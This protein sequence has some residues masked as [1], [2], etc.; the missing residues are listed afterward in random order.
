MMNSKRILYGEVLMRKQSRFLKR[1]KKKLRPYLHTITLGAMVGFFMASL[2]GAA[3]AQEGQGKE[4]PRKGRPPHLVNTFRHKGDFSVITVGTGS[5]AYHPERSGPSALVH[6]KGHYFLIDMGNGT[7]A[8]LHEAGI[9]A[10]D[11]NTILFTHLHLDHSEEFI[12][13][14]INAWLQ[15]QDHLKIMGPPQTREYHDFLI[16]IYEEDMAYRAWRTGRSITIIKS[17]EIEELKGENR[18]VD[19]GV[20]ISTVDVPHTVY[21]LAYRFDA[22]GK[23]IVISGDLGYSENLITLSKNADVLVIDASSYIRKRGP[24]QGPPRRRPK[25]VQTGDKHWPKPHASL[26]EVAQMAEKAKAKKIVLT[27]F[28]PGNIDK[29]GTVE[30]IKKTYHGDIIFGRDLLETIP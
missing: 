22:D 17:M 9:P 24:G 12:P 13:I 30:V 16:R 10:R 14:V 1:I 2:G 18:F 29:E 28:G 25:R 26:E 11:I 5:P 15:G 7:Q 3:V 23:S 27:H 20:T 8:R 19:H 6:Y 4:R 21:T